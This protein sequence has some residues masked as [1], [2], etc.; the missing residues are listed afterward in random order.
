MNPFKDFTRL[1]WFLFAL[2]VVGLLAMGWWVITAPGR[3]SA[4][5]AGQTLAEGRSVAATDASEVRDRADERTAHI[6]DTVKGATD[7]VRNAES[8]AARNDA[9]LRGLCRVDPGASP[10]CGLLVADPARNPR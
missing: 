5:K 2:L 1:A 4:A 8:P 3:E 9:A 7:D 6:N 10:R